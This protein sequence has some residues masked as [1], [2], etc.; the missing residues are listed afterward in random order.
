M[1]E[2]LI[3]GIPGK[4]YL[5]FPAVFSSFQPHLGLQTEETTMSRDADIEIVTHLKTVS[6]IGTISYDGV[7]FSDKSNK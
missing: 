3:L 1:E 5:P 2:S 7:Q 4:L 6:Q